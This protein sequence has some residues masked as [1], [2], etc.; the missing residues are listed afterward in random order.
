MYV[1]RDRYRGL[2]IFNN[3][4]ERNW[5]TLRWEDKE[6]RD[7]TEPFEIDY[8]SFDISWDDEPVKIELVNYLQ[9]KNEKLAHE[10]MSAIYKEEHKD[11]LFTF[12][13]NL[14]GD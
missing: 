4:P 1:A 13:D 11:C 14:E 8:R 6:D 7:N 12:T 9:Y 2:H 3:K 10:Y 5:T